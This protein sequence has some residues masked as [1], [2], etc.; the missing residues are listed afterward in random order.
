MSVLREMD[1]PAN[2]VAPLP[3]PVTWAEEAHE[4]SGMTSRLIL[5]YLEHRG[6][7]ATVDRVLELCG[8]EDA[9]PDLR[10]DG[11]WVSFATK[12]RLL[13]AAS[14]GNRACTTCRGS[15]GARTCASLS[16][17]WP[18]SPRCS[19]PP[20]CSIPRGCPRPERP[21]QCSWWWPAAACSTSADAPGAS[22]RPRCATKPS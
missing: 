6:G 10:D 19:P 7:R 5:A 15:R 11:H 12:V 16:D 4:T 8:L 9:E 2:T 21:P 18:A 22:S 20:A 14:A 13:I 17:R 1:A 3:P